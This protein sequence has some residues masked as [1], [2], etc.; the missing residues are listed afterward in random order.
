MSLRRMAL[1]L[2]RSKVRRIWGYGGSVWTRMLATLLCLALMGAVL[3]LAGW[4]V[5]L[6]VSHDAL[7]Q[8]LAH[9]QEQVRPLDLPPAPALP[10]EQQRAHNAAVTQLNIPWSGLLDVLERQSQPEVAILALEPDAQRQ[11]V[12]V[13]A[14][15]KD[16]DT[17]IRYAEGLAKQ[18]HLSELRLRRQEINDLDPNRPVRLTFDVR[19]SDDRTSTS[20][21]QL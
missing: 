14:E 12:R 4:A 7:A 13:V 9:R 18:N 17:L 19:W 11:L 1:V 21:G 6:R 10:P 3:G 16:A 2:D 20:G 15:A 8:E 5:H